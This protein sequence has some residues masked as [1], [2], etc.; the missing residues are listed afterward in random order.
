M[1]AALSPRTYFIKV[2][3]GNGWRAQALDER[4]AS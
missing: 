4:R 2:E 3:P 1:N